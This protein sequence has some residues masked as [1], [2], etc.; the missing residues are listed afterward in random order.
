VIA[1]TPEMVDAGELG[2][3]VH[4]VSDA[5]ASDAS[6]AAPGNGAPGGADRAD[7]VIELDEV[8][9]TVPTA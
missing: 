3:A 1:E 4:G 8:D 2:S 7:G 5:G 6:N 9:D